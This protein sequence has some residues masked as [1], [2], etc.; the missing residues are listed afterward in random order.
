M[1]SLPEKSMKISLPYFCINWKMTFR[2]VVAAAWK[3]NKKKFWQAPL[4]PW[5]VLSWI[6]VFSGPWGPIFLVKNRYSHI[7][8]PPGG[9]PYQSL[10]LRYKIEKGLRAV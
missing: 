5:H 2:K 9:S 1:K 6:W 10:F 3:V 7:F 8:P 4:G